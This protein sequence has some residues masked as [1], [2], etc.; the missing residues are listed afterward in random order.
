MLDLAAG[1]K[2]ALCLPPAHQL[3]AGQAG[4]GHLPQPEE[5]RG[6]RG[7]GLGQLASTHVGDVVLGQAAGCDKGEGS[8]PNLNAPPHQHPQ[9]QARADLGTPASS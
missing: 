3:S 2:G 6:Q 9:P 8:G 4:V 1:T 5:G 7:Q